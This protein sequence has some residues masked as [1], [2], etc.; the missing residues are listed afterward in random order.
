MMDTV[1]KSRFCGE[2]KVIG[3]K[4]TV[5]G[6]DGYPY[7]VNLIDLKVDSSVDS[8]GDLMERISGWERRKA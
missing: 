4:L 5:V 1:W 7:E 2:V 6:T 8:A 3:G